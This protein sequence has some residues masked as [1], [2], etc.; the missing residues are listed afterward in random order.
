MRPTISWLTWP[1]EHHLHDVHGGLVGDAQPGD[2]S[3]ADAHLLQR[4]VD[5]RSA[6]VD[7]DDLDADV[8]QEADVLGEARLELGVDHGVAAVFDDERAPMKAPDV[9]ERLV[10]N[11]GFLD[12]V[13][14]AGA[15]F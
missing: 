10:Q 1:A 2:E 6:A 4:G 13:L 12:E 14:H 7:H 11:G 9:R 8:A 5:L 3:G 15:R